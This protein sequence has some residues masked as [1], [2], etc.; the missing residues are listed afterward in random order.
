MIHQL[1]DTP[2]ALADQAAQMAMDEADR[3]WGKVQRWLLGFV[4]LLAGVMVW[5]GVVR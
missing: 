5:L 3:R 2:S 4:W 1:R